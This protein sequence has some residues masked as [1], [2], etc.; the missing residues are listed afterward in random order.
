MKENEKVREYSRGK[1]T[2]IWKPGL[3]IHSGVCVKALPE[4]Y[5]PREKPWIRP[6]LASEQA[7]KEQIARCPSGAL[8][9]RES[10]ESPTA[11]SD[12]PSIQVVPGGPL[13]L[14]GRVQLDHA[15]GTQTLE[16]RSALCRCGGSSKKPFCDGS[17][18]QLNFE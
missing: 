7:L 15:G 16:G 10:D 3:C 17:H 13:I 9:F 12:L 6:E 8:S 5:R 14:R 1:L 2:I 11:A 4:V 18:K